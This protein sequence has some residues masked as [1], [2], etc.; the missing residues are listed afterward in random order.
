[1]KA[2]MTMEEMAAELMRQSQAKQDFIFRSPQLEFAPYET[3][4]ILRILDDGGADY[5]EPLELSE[6]AH[7]QIGARLSIP[8]KYYDRMKE[9]YPELLAQNVNSWFRKTPANRMVR[10][11]DGMARAFLSDSYR[12][13]D[14]LL[15][16][17]A[18]MPIIGGIEGARFESCQITENQMYIKI[19]NPHLQAEISE[20]DIVQAGL[21]VTNSEVGTGSFCVQPMLYRLRTQTGMIDTPSQIR[22]IHKGRVNTVDVNTLLA[23]ETEL[24]LADR[25]FLAAIQ[26]TVRTAVNYLNFQNVVQ[27]MR[28]AAASQMN[29]ENV[30]LVVQRAGREFGV[31]EVENDGVLHRL[32]EDNDLTLYGLSNAVARHSQDVPNY[33]RATEL[34]AIGYNM[35]TMTGQQWNQL[36]QTAA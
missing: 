5:T 26:E 1:M 30:P 21:V 10:A 31:T 14:H 3:G 27:T 8:A 36:N 25:T 15:V 4:M 17:Q 16:A 35:M 9:C 7:R 29:T 24:T 19:V 33:D 32:V 28:D 20:G 34:E 6:N 2:G 18:V 12:R 13:I 23:P 22:R 11:M